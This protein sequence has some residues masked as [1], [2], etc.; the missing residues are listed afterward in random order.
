MIRCEPPSSL[1]PSPPQTPE[2]DHSSDFSKPQT[3][4]LPSLEQ[5]I[6][7]IV[8]RS[9]VQVPTLMSS[10][11]YLD[12]LQK[13]L[14]P[15][16][17]GM[18]CTV[19]R[20]FLASLI[21]AAKN[22]ND[23]S[24]KN[25]HWARY[26]VVRGFDGFGFSLTEVN[27]MEKQLLFLLDW[28]LRITQQ[29]LHTHLEPFLTPIIQKHNRAVELHQEKRREKER[30]RERIEYEEEQ[31]ILALRRAMLHSRAK[32]V[33]QTHTPPASYHSPMYLSD[34]ATPPTQY[35]VTPASPP[36]SSS[37][38][39][40]SRSSQSSDRSEDYRHNHSRSR[41]HQR[42]LTVDSFYDTPPSSTPSTGSIP[43]LACSSGTSSSVA[44]SQDNSP[45]IPTHHVRNLLPTLDTGK[46][47][48][49]LG[50]TSSSLL[51]RFLA[52]GPQQQSS[53]EKLAAC[54]MTS[55]RTG[56]TLY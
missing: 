52:V 26:S 49:R 18:P 36:P 43:A 55:S 46:K 38:S 24:P 6:T 10:L 12:R 37:S 32:A 28:D 53:P 31:Q 20:I 13:K 44:S 25:K 39:S 3:P 54:V 7:S 34:M 5:F 50:G 14:P 41:G 42:S 15:V 29:D 9:H 8:D 27:L 21:L 17:K 4:S 30:K 47:K 45:V 35:T 51:S 22:L 19:H 33:T 40:C 23:S 16:A 56:R 11:V 48:I 1:P 2:R